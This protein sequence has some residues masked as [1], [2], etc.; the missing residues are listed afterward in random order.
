MNTPPQRQL[1]NPPPDPH[2]RRPAHAPPPDAWDC[3]LHLFGPA[4]DWPF[5]SHSPYTSD[6]ALPE[7]YLA[8]QDVLG[9]RYG[10]I[11]S[12]GGYGRDH[13]HLQWV[14]ER[15]PERL[16]GIVLARDDLRLEEAN[17][18]DALGVRGIRFF[19]GPPG[20]EWSH[21]PTIDPRNAA[22][23]NALGW[24]VQYQSLVRCHIV[25]V[26][27]ALLAL[28]NRIVLD[29]FGGF[30]PALGQDQ[31]AFR[32]IL[33]MLDSGRVWLKLSAPMRCADGDFP[34]AVMR[35]FVKT[36]V[37]HAPERLLWGSDWPHVQLIGRGMP[38]D[39]DLV[40][41]MADWVPDEATR[42][43]IFAVNPRE[44]YL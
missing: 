1:H 5:E 28:P 25:A 14:L 42:D 7:D 40:D 3:H 8:L 18:L 35:P 43:R 16:R 22:L 33:R 32:T 19:A 21:L 6:D 17:R 39:G 15:F 4:K 20:H 31:P 24:H 2:P 12:A 9:L 41:L 44:L 11:V 10:V 27:D 13:R 34:W 38:N 26:A 29:H 23:V 37:R 30:D 36:L